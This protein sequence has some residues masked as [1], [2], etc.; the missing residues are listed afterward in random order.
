MLELPE[1]LLVPPRRVHSKADKDG[2]MGGGLVN[3]QHVVEQQQHGPLELVRY[4][5]QPTAGALR[6]GDGKQGLRI[7]RMALVKLAVGGLKHLVL[8]ASVV[9]DLVAV[10]T[11]AP[12]GEAG[13]AVTA[14]EEDMSRR[15]PEGFNIQPVHDLVGP[16]EDVPLR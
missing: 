12:V 16:P 8:P 3:F 6:V 7:E 5:P 2:G 15:G 13:L 11:G 10:G 4:E 14:Q 1:S 9:R